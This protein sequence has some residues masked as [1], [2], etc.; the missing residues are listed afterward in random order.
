MGAEQTDLPLD[1][2]VAEL[3]REAQKAVDREIAARI[4]LAAAIENRIA[5]RAKVAAGAADAVAFIDNYVSPVVPNPAP[6][7]PEVA[8]PAPAIEP[9]VFTT[10][11]SAELSPET[12]SGGRAPVIDDLLD[13][14]EAPAPVETSSEGEGAGESGGADTSTGK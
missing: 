8:A 14:P 1:A 7:A 9:P 6:L 3:R 10:V 11:E 13:V 2:D 5:V 4:E 12:T